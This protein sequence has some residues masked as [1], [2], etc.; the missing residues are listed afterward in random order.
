MTRLPS[1][2]PAVGECIDDLPELV[3]EGQPIRAGRAVGLNDYLR[4]N[5]CASRSI[6][7]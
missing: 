2:N 3:I 4:G 5:C 1:T 6:R 7:Y